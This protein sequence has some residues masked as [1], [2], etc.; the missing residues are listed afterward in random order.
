MATNW[1][2]ESDGA[3]RGPIS[4]S[5]IR[6]LVATG[7]ITPST[8][9][10]PADRN[11]WMT[12]GQLRGLFKETATPRKEP[13]PA[14]AGQHGGAWYLRDITGAT[15]GPVTKAQLDEWHQNHQISA[16]CQ[17]R[18]N[19]WSEWQGAAEVYPSLKERTI[20]W[21]QARTIIAKIWRFLADYVQGYFAR[22]TIHWSPA[23]PHLRRCI[24]NTHHQF[25]THT[26]CIQCG[27]Q[28]VG[29][30]VNQVANG[31]DA[32]LQEVYN[33]WVN[34]KRR[35]WRLFTWSLV[36]SVVLSLVLFF[37]TW[38]SL[39]LV[40]FT[41]AIGSAI[42]FFAARYLNTRIQRSIDGGSDK[43]RQPVATQQ[44]DEVNRE[45]VDP[46]LRRNEVPLGTIPPQDAFVLR[47]LKS[48]DQGTDVLIHQRE[49]H[50]LEQILANKRITLWNNPA[51]AQLV[52]SAFALKNDYSL[53]QQRIEHLEAAGMSVLAAY[54]S[55]VNNDE[56]FLP[57]LQQLLAERQIPETASSLLGMLEA[58]RHELRLRGFAKD[59]EQRRHGSMSITMEM[60]DAMDP[61]NFELLLG[62]IYETQGFRI[63]ETPKSGDQGADVL[64]EKAGERTVIQAKLYSDSV[65]NKAVQEAIAARSH[66]RCHAAKVVTNSYFTPSAQQLAQSSDVQ[67]IGREELSHMIDEFN[68]ST[69]DYSRL[70]TL[71]QAATSTTGSAGGGA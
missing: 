30:Q 24:A 66:F 46:F 23:A 29:L 65:G 1:Y 11:D 48:L 53:F 37:T 38:W 68:R 64:I 19:D 21:D 55:L 33:I 71:I 43:V 59:L 18:H 36:V 10:R 3:E 52:L 9:V 28:S 42:P 34:G 54:A 4:G 69:K 7:E 58:V 8:R 44:I 2:Y 51:S 14:A 35:V 63:I 12:A 60:V 56:A 16:L 40:P 49:L 13:R 15:F 31:D 25:S 39:V 26:A 5:D 6:K 70:A 17:I 57:F 47:R 27:Q 32:Q 20:D 22:L 50:M 41:L 61:Y 67:L 45:Y 62:M